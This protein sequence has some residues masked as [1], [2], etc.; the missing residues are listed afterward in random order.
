MTP[1]HDPYRRVRRD[2]ARSRLIVN[3]SRVTMTCP[4]IAGYINDDVALIDG[5]LCYP[6]PVTRP[7]NGI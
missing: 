2:L 4:L 7:A 6:V 5:S 3:P 1:G